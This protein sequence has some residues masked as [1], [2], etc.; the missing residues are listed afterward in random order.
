MFSMSSSKERRN[1]R[2]ILSRL[3]DVQP[4]WGGES[5]ESKNSNVNLYLETSINNFK[6]EHPVAYRILTYKMN[7]YIPFCVSK[8][9]DWRTWTCT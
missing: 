2:M 1:G 7:H 6:S 3:D 9:A 5:A 8:E 4:H